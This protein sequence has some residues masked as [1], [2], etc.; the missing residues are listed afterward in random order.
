[1]VALS[2]DKIYPVWAVDKNDFT[3]KLIAT[4]SKSFNEI[5]SRLYDHG[6]KVDE[7]LTEFYDLYFRDGH[8]KRLYK[9]IELLGQGGYGKVF[10][11]IDLTTLIYEDKNHY[12][13]E[14]QAVKKISFGKK[15][16]NNIRREI[17]MYSFIHK[18]GYLKVAQH[19]NAWVE[20]DRSSDRMILYILME[21]CE[22]TL[23]SLINEI[24]NDENYEKE[25]M[26]TPLGFYL[27]G[28]IFIEILESVQDLHDNKIIQRF[29][30]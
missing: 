24:R 6:L 9:E 26:L 12:M 23:E 2:S 18:L 27:A 20:H 14:Y 21:Y 5:F 7:K 4:Y 10:K 22:K 8:Y 29:E 25:K 15:H 1:M 17:Y 3:W 11:V 13:I 16:I 19:F 30:S 28:Q